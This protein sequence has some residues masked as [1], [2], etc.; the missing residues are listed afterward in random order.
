MN[1]GR[2]GIARAS[3]STRSHTIQEARQREADGQPDRGDHGSGNAQA[4]LQ[5]CGHDVCGRCHIVDTRD[6]GDGL[7]EFA[8]LFIDLRN[9]AVIRTST[10][11]AVGPVA[12]RISTGSVTLLAH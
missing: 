1:L 2:I 3:P 11:L 4:T 5:V 9:K 7:L 12:C 10:T 8:Q 6:R